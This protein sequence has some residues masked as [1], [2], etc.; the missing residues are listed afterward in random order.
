VLG[1]DLTIVAVTEAYLRATMTRRDDILGRGLFDVFPDNPDDPGATGV[2]NLRASIERVIA[3]E[4]PD[5]MAVQKYDIRR[6]ES[7]GGRFEE[8]YWSPANFPVLND[9]GRVAYIIHYVED[10]TEL[11][12]LKR[13]ESEHHRSLRELAAR[14]AERHEQLLDT[15]PDAMVVVED[16]G[17]IVLVNI[18]TERLFGYARAELIGQPMEVLIPQRFRR[19]HAVHMHRF[20]ALPAARA[21]GAGAERKRGKKG[22]PRGKGNRKQRN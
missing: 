3:E 19:A 12:R 1:P 7:E 18:Q 9:D 14:S 11:V 21:M 10:V 5:T 15:A 20:F 13:Q 22:R 2:A 4:W 6:P 8:R 17:R 16:D